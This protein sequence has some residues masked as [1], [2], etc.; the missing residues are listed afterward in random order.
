M[1]QND[2][3]ANIILRLKDEFSKKLS[4]AGKDFQNFARSVDQAGAAMSRTGMKMVAV[5]TA[6]NAP[7]FAATKAM[8]NYSFAARNEMIRLNNE[9]LSLSKVVAE[10]AMPTIKA[11]NDNFSRLVN[12]LK[13]IDP[14]L[15]QNIAHWAMVAGQVLI[16]AGTI[17]IFTGKVLSLLARMFSPINLIIIAIGLLTYAWIQ[18]HDAFMKVL[19]AIDIGFNHFVLFF[20]R[21]WNE[22]S[23][24][25][26]TAIKF[27]GDI[28]NKWIITQL[29]GL[30]TLGEGY[31]SLSKFVPQ[32]AGT[33]G[34]AEIAIRKLD[35]QITKFKGNLNTKAPSGGLEDMIA[36]FEKNISDAKA[37]NGA[38]AQSVNNLGK[39]IQKFAVDFKKAFE[40]ASKDLDTVMK[41]MHS[42][43]LDTTNSIADGFADAFDKVLFEGE[44]F[45]GSMKSLFASLGRS[46]VKDFVS[47][48]GKNLFNA[49]LGGAG[50][51]SGTGLGGLIGAGMGSIFGPIGTAIGG[52]LGGMFKFHEGGMIYAHAGLAPDEVPIIAQSGEGV[53][54]RRGMAAIGGSSSLRA[55]NKGEAP[56]GGGGVTVVINQV[57]KAWDSNDVYRNS[58]TLTA[59]MANEIR[60]NGDLRRAIKET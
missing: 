32:L 45:A 50:T 55:I 38:F 33:G 59:A 42:R 8:E 22:I 5:G 17:E 46:I 1:A 28:F 23:K 9:F 60:T 3:V 19:N 27:M 21:Y 53:L 56:S 48:V 6:L 54:S 34:V 37:G 40:N 20:L 43:I 18:H 25:M 30:K 16:V 36:A 26:D 24:G 14:V 41:D 58:K 39:G 49:L 13:T 7:F 11:F 29:E 10:A 12:A 51:N 57:V 4:T 52:F 2:Q 47:T 31:K 44:S 15:L 35:E